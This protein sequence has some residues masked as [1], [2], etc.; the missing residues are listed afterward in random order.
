VNL[1]L[2]LL[3]LAMGGAIERWTQGWR[4]R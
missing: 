3:H 4:R 2:K 1:G